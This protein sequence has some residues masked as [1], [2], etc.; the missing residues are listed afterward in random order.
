MKETSVFR[1]V[2]ENSIFPRRSQ[3]YHGRYKISSSTCLLQYCCLRWSWYFT[4]VSMPLSL[5][6]SC[7][8]KRRLPCRLC[9]AIIIVVFSASPSLHFASLSSLPF[10]RVSISAPPPPS[11]PLLALVL[12]LADTNFQTDQLFHKWHPLMESLRAQPR[13]R[14]LVRMKPDGSGPLDNMCGCC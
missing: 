6:L 2:F 11:L 7:L 4:A 10:P 12:W 5:S 9:V 3:L 13:L 14:F 1:E 8:C